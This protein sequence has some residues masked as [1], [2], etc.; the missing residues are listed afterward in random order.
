MVIGERG[1]QFCPYHELLIYFLFC[2]MSKGR[3]FLKIDKTL[4]WS[5]IRGGQSD[6][7]LG[8]FLNHSP[9]IIR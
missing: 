6:L 5:I 3:R 2:H 4:T 8:G 7:I 1:T 9:L